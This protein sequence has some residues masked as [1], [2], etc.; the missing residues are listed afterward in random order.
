MHREVLYGRH[1][2]EE[3]LASFSAVANKPRGGKA[4]RS[5]RSRGAIAPGLVTF[6]KKMAQS[7]RRVE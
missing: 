3:T 1:N 2:E 7:A 6:D 5:G 4:F